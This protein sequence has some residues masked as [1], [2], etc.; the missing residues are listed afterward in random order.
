[1]MVYYR[2]SIVNLI[3]NTQDKRI[4]KMFNNFLTSITIKAL[5][6]LIIDRN[7]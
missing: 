4:K 2:L 3:S 1:M 5:S 7:L 6:F